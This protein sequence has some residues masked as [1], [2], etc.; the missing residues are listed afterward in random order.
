MGPHRVAVCA[1]KVTLF[2]LIPDDLSWAASKVL[3]NGA[4]LDRAPPETL[5]PP[6]RR[7]DRPAPATRT[8]DLYANTPVPTNVLTPRNAEALAT[9]IQPPTPQRETRL[10]DRLMPAPSSAAQLEIG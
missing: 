7:I 9:K 10:A 4:D 3:A 5:T 6:P 1:H 8:S 2:D